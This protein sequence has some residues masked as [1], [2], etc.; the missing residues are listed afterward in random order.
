MTTASLV[1]VVG[2]KRVADSASVLPSIRSSVSEISINRDDVSPEKDGLRWK[3]KNSSSEGTMPSW[4]T[5]SAA[6]KFG[7]G[8]GCK[9][10]AIAFSRSSST[11][12]SLTSESSKLVLSAT[13]SRLYLLAG[14]VPSLTML[15]IQFHP[16]YGE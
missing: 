7:E 14:D 4:G 11:V 2:S 10:S 8:N 13:E 16:Y 3:K 12:L 15:R 9:A 5:Q 6:L 1:V